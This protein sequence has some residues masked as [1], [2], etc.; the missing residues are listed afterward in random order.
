MGDGLQLREPIDESRRLTVEGGGYSF[1][2]TQLRP[3][4]LA[5]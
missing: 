2:R 3:A 4:S 1:T 5:S